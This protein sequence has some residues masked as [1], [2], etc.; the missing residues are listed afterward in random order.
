MLY[1]IRG[2]RR[3]LSHQ[4]QSRIYEYTPYTVDHSAFIYLMG[5]NGEYLGSFPLGASA[6]RLAE[7]IRPRLAAD[8]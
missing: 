4:S 8:R 7:I 5:R 3:V 2:P 6:D 1:A